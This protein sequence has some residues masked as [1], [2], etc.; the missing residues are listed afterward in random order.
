MEK[1]PLKKT[2]TISPQTRSAEKITAPAAPILDR[3]YPET[4]T[5]AAYDALQEGL[6]QIANSKD[7][8]KHRVVNKVAYCAGCFIGGNQLSFNTAYNTIYGEIIKRGNLNDAAKA[9]K[10]ILAAL[11]KGM[12]KPSFESK[13]TQKETSKKGTDVFT[14]AVEYMEKKYENL[15]KNELTTSLEYGEGIEISEQEANS[16]YIELREMDVAIRK[17]D[18]DTLLN[19]NRFKSKNPLK[20]FFTSNASLVT[21]GSTTNIDMVVRSI[22]SPLPIEFLLVFIYKW[23]VGIIGNLFSNNISPLCLVLVG[24]KNIGKTEFFR[25]LL[26][27]FLKKYFAQ[28][29]FGQGKDS[30]ALMCEYLIVMSDEMEYMQKGEAKDFRSYLG[31]DFFVNRPS[32]GRKNVRKKRIASV[33]GTSNENNIIQDPEN[34]RRI[35]PIPI[36]SIDY[37]LYNSINKTALFIELYHLFLQGFN[38]QLVSED[39][40]LL[41]LHTTEFEMRRPEIETILSL[42]KVPKTESDLKE[43]GEFT[44]SHIAARVSTHSGHRVSAIT[45]GKCLKEIGFTSRRVKITGTKN[46]SVVYR[47]VE[48]NSYHGVIRPVGGVD[49]VP[50]G[51]WMDFPILE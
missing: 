39:I 49:P 19:S 11:T 50:P 20:D 3:N 29:R 45:V 2:K 40:A 23:L 30:D 44:A 14:T 34:N 8:E 31:Q 37:D 24:P 38:Y 46:S 22:K 12:E 21:P 51:V 7:G 13:K 33:C 25:R 26:A 18:F 36:E 27:D 4:P 15:H 10:T 1:F 16:V 5:Q 17:P 43:S 47:A 41:E 6:R 48:G 9:E 42:Y 28:T 35:I 32:Y